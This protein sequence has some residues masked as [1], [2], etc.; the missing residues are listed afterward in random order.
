MPN[1]VWQQFVL[2]QCVVIAKVNATSI[3]INTVQVKHS[4]GCL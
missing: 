2:V 4:I 1:G 3:K